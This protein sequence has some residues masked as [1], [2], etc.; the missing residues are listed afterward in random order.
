MP[1]SP[2]TSHPVQL[3]LDLEDGVSRR[4]TFNVATTAVTTASKNKEPV[5]SCLP[6]C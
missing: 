1:Y 3:H 6:I 2:T 5:L 4:L